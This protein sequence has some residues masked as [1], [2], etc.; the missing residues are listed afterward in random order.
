MNPSPATLRPA[1]PPAF[2]RALCRGLLILLAFLLISCDR[3][4]RW[5]TTLPGRNPLRVAA[6][7]VSAQVDLSEAAGDELWIISRPDG[8]RGRRTGNAAQAG[9]LVTRID[10]R[11]AGLP[12]QA[13]E[14]NARISGDLVTVSYLQH[15]ANPYPDPIE[16]RYV[17]PL[18]ENAAVR[19][20]LMVM[21]ERRIRGVVRARA[22][23]EELYR[24]AKRQGHAASLLTQERPNVFTQTVANIAP[25]GAIDVSIHYLHA[26][27][28]LDGWHELVVPLTVAPRFTPSH[29]TSNSSP[30]SPSQ[31]PKDHQPFETATSSPDRAGS[32]SVSL[33]LEVVGTV[34][35]HEC[36]SHA[37]ETGDRTAGRQEFRL[38]PAADAATR[39]FVFRYRIA[40]E[41]VK[42]QF[43]AYQT[44]DDGFF[45]LTLYP[46]R[47]WLTLDPI[48]LEL[49]FVLD[50]SGSMSGRPIEQAK[51]AV[52]H[53]LSSL[54]R[55]DSFQ[56]ITFSMTASQL[57]PRPMA[58]T[59]GNIRRALDYVRDLRGEDG[60]M[61]LNGIRAALRF[62]HDPSRLRFICFLTDGLIGNESEILTEVARELGESRI[63]SC[64][65]G[66]AP[67][68]YL[69]DALARMGRG[70]AAYLSLDQDPVKV[71]DDFLQR[72]AHPAL[73]DIR[74]DWGD[75]PVAELYPPRPADLFVGR[76]VS[77]AGRLHAHGRHTIHI[78]GR[79]HQQSVRMPL[80]IDLDPPAGGVAALETLWARGKIGYLADR[81]LRSPGT[82]LARR[83]R[84]VALE[85]GLMSSYT[86]FVAVD[87]AH[88]GSRTR[89]KTIE[90]P[91]QLPLGMGSPA[92]RP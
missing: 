47:Q 61:M 79:V 9:R 88:A 55:E 77:V 91:S 81:M 23:A 15:Y 65:V 90:T 34:E 4:A 87:G 89:I 31:V 13:T 37:I 70:A 11:E 24:E 29:W 7:A 3:R 38:I 27:P 71:M 75:L 60:T 41:T 2:A 16:A 58:A 54:Q 12:L 92:E 86:A 17:F 46:P 39:D 20:F 83:I 53:A 35:E 63:F 74:I 19:D 68:R 82:D 57:G 43:Q 32:P 49:V 84:Q 52:S 40:G 33:A 66:S 36:L 26:L 59:P 69:M 6:P 50:C 78:T 51:A 67:N 64:G 10:G 30:S 42:T 21:G 62:P 48:P 56:I 5:G 45:R 22:E 14:V 44:E 18:P 25:G 1:F 28:F 72:I 73:T 80:E 85:Y 76:T 8:S